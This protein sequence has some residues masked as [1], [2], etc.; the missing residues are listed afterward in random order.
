[1]QWTN[2]AKILRRKE[3]I[4]N[5]KNHRHALVSYMLRQLIGPIIH[6]KFSDKILIDFLY[7]IRLSIFFGKSS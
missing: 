6:R 7:E 2:P 4:L 3:N 5:K 1:M